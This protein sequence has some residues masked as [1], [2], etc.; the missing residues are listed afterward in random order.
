MKR[1]LIN[2]KLFRQ[3]SFF[4]DVAK[5]TNKFNDTAVLVSAGVEWRSW[6]VFFV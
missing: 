1:N 5:L 2:E 3:V 4:Y 6:Q